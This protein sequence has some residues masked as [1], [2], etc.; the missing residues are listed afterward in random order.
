[1]DL[2]VA[3]VVIHQE[4]T[5][6][7]DLSL[8]TVPPAPEISQH[9]VLMVGKSNWQMASIVGMQLLDKHVKQPFYSEEM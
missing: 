1:V 6:L 2:E 3:T 5:R 8:D 9:R 7:G 4:R